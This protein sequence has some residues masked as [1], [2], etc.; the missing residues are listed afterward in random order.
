MK[1]PKKTICFC[2]KAWTRQEYV[3]YIIKGLYDK[4]LI[5]EEHEFT[6]APK[7]RVDWFF[8][9]VALAIDYH[10]RNH[11]EPVRFFGCLPA[12]ARKTFK[13]QQEADQRKARLMRKNKIL[14]LVIW[15]TD[16][17]TPEGIRRKIM[18]FLNRRKS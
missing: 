7:M 16:D 11:S 9:N 12:T 1:E 3:G 15:W 18:R 2:G 17:L 14:Y 13:R 8:P 4:V 6:F 5:L 10:G